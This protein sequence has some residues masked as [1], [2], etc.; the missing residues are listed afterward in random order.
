MKDNDILTCSNCGDE[1][2]EL[3]ICDFCERQLCSDCLDQLN[4]DCTTD[5][6]TGHTYEKFL[7]D[8]FD[9]DIYN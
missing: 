8:Q 5:K 6:P 9:D 3:F 7:M 2:E 4:H 1:V